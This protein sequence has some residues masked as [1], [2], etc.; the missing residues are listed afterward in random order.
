MNKVKY[1]ILDFGKVL[2]APTTG[3][4]FIT[5]KFY[6]IVNEEKI[7]KDKLLNSFKKYGNIISEKLLTE[8]E[9]YDMFYRFY[10]NVFENCEYEILDED[11]KK[12]AKEITYEDGKY[13]MYDNV[14]N[15]LELLSSKYKLLLLSDNWPCVFRIMKNWKIDKY[16]EKIYVSSVYGELKE[17]GKFFDYPINDFEIKE[18]EAIFVDDNI[19]LLKVA[20]TK[21]LKVYLMDREK[22]TEKTTV[23]V[24][25][26][27]IELMNIEGE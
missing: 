8:A 5:P 17:N 24:I 19:D 13:T 16:F 21:G 18:N 15:E 6:E 20:K 14:I 26:D 25:N 1:I 4:W 27:L 23:R 3:Q 2:A 11:I 10:K 7:N 12:I 22:N 9:E